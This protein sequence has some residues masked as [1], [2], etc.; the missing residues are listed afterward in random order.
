MRSDNGGKFVRARK[1]FA[2][3]SI[4]GTSLRFTTT[5]SNATTSGPLTHLLGYGGVWERC[6]RT[7]RKVLRALTKEQVLDDEGQI[8]YLYFYISNPMKIVR[9]AILL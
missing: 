7:V 5:F 6:I 8:A 2:M 3:Q 1:N 9:Y 4:T